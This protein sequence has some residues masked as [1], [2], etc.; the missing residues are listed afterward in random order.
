M[1][2][3]KKLFYIA[4]LSLIITLAVFFN[5]VHDKHSAIKNIF[6]IAISTLF[7]TLFLAMNFFALSWLVKKI[8]RSFTK[9]NKS[10]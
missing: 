3:K 9:K 7:L 5:T 4:I 2:V 1:T 6:E 10:L 8:S